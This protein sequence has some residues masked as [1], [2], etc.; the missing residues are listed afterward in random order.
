MSD[1]SLQ[2]IAFYKEHLNTNRCCLQDQQTLLKVKFYNMIKTYARCIDLLVSA[3]SLE[4][5]PGVLFCW[6]ICNEYLHNPQS[7]SSTFQRNISHFQIA[8][9]LEISCALFI[10]ITTLHQEKFIYNMNVICKQHLITITLCS[11]RYLRMHY[12]NLSYIFSDN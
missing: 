1:T 9:F 12:N 8:Q 3:I 6:S 11:V 2:V 4:T 7:S 5:G 10:Y